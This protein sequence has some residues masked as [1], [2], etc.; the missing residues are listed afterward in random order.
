[1]HGPVASRRR[2]AV[3]SARVFSEGKL[4]VK[5]IDATLPDFGVPANRPELQR[6]VY[7]ARLDALAPALN[8]DIDTILAA[9]L[10]ALASLPPA[11]IA[12]R[13]R[14]QA[15]TLC[16]VRIPLMAM[17]SAID[18]PGFMPGPLGAYP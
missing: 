3:R 9:D 16:L 5:L 12:R 1:M 18:I 14:M 15:A 2:S 11:D 8:G 6:A 17:P 13:R 10:V 4:S 7:A